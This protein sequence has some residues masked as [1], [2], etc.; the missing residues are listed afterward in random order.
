TSSSTT[1]LTILG[2]TT[3]PVTPTTFPYTTLFRSSVTLT[4]NYSD[5]DVGDTHT[6]SVDTTG[7]LG[8]VVSNGD[9]T[10][11]YSPNGAFES[12]K[13]GAEGTGTRRYSRKACNW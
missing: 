13:A 7:T 11:T 3:A 12:L 1:T 2:R 10:F 9:G 8:S 5:V 6:F 4:A